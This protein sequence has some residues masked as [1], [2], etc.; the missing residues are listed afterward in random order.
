MVEYE[1]RRDQLAE[2]PDFD[3]SQASQRPWSERAEA[4]EIGARC[5]SAADP[6]VPEVVTTGCW[7]GCRLTRVPG[8]ISCRRFLADLLVQNRERAPAGGG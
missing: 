7:P 4:F 5:D 1:R 3:R 8:G 6:Y 2:S